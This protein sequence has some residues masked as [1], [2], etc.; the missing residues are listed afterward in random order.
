MELSE[1]TLKESLLFLTTYLCEKDFSTLVYLKNKY[2]NRL[3]I[4]RDRFNQ[5]TTEQHHP[6]HH[7]SV[8][9][10]GTTTISLKINKHKYE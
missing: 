4:S 3:L 6:K 2:R 10:N 5:D 9:Y 1:L 8:R 7:D